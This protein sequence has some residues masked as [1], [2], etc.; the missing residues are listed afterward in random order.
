MTIGA[1][2]LNR[3]LGHTLRLNK[4][5]GCDVLTL[6][7]RLDCYNIDYTHEDGITHE[8]ILHI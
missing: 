1:Q 5:S 4:S 3:K 8:I 6:C 2:W 7:V